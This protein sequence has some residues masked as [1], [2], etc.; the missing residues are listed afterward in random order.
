MLYAT[1]AKLL[2]RAIPSPAQPAARRDLHRCLVRVL[3]LAEL[4]LFLAFGVLF[5]ICLPTAVTVLKTNTF[6][7][8]G[9]DL[10]ETLFVCLELGVAACFI[11]VGV[12]G[13]RLLKKLSRRS[14]RAE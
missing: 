11:M 4:P 6:Q 2:E 10:R 8:W 7:I 5:Y 14:V 3:L 12:V 13:I 9:F 1:S